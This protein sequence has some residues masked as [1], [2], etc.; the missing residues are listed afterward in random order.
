[1]SDRR[2]RPEKEYAESCDRDMRHAGVVVS[3]KRVVAAI[4]TCVLQ[5]QERQTVSELR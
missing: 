3:D 2:S 4:E 1:M 5:V